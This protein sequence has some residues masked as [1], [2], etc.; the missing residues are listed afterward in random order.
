[1][2]DPPTSPWPAHSQHCGSGWRIVP[3]F[4]RPSVVGHAPAAH[5]ADSCNDCGHEHQNPAA[6]LPAIAAIGMLEF[7]E[8][9][10]VEFEDFEEV[11]DD[12]AA[13]VVVM[14]VSLMEVGGAKRRS[15]PM[16]DDGDHWFVAMSNIQVGTQC[17]EIFDAFVG[18]R[19]VSA[20]GTNA[21]KRQTLQGCSSARQKRRSHLP[22][23]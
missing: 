9:I 3:T 16:V 8:E 23:L 11:E 6:T 22:L 4:A 18:S 19:A 20:S 5:D 14:A 7:A 2:L 21:I 10:K 17:K 15:A 13:G 1:M 12:I